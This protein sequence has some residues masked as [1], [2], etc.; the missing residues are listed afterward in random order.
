MRRVNQSNFVVSRGSM[1]TISICWSVLLI[2]ALGAKSSAQT[3]STGALSGT[4]TDSSGA[5]VAGVTVNITNEATG[6]VRHQST[7]ADGS[8]LAPLLLPGTYRVEVVGKGFKTLVVSKVPIFVTEK[9]DLHLALQVGTATENVDV[10]AQAELLKTED[11]A[12]GNVT[13]GQTVGEL[14]LVRRRKFSADS[15]SLCA[16]ITTRYARRGD[17]F[18]HLEIEKVTCIAGLSIP[19]AQSA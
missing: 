14:P 16:E 6:D 15:G 1:A 7:Q 13:D 12:L 10:E 4:V 18:T 19:L 5:V 17:T 11:S 9:K 3:A 2:L 8:F